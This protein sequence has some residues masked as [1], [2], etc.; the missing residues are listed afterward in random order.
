MQNQLSAV[1]HPD[2]RKTWLSEK[3][4]SMLQIVHQSILILTLLVYKTGNKFPNP[5]IM[6]F[7]VFIKVWKLQTYSLPWLHTFLQLF[8]GFTVVWFHILGFPKNTLLR[9]VCS[10]KQANKIEIKIGSFQLTAFC[11]FLSL[12]TSCSILAAEYFRG[13]QKVFW[14]CSCAP[15]LFSPL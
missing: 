8:W 5:G 11:H 6:K 7:V 12:E 9:A 2:L 13:T 1:N 15:L 10:L 4:S 14:A 3:L